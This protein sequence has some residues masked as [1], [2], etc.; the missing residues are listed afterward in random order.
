MS[1]VLQLWSISARFKYRNTCWHLADRPMIKMTFLDSTFYLKWQHKL[2]Q[3]LFLNWSK[4][5]IQ[6]AIVLLA[7]LFGYSSTVGPVIF[8]FLTLSCYNFRFSF[9]FV[10]YLLA[11]S[12]S[13]SAP[14]LVI[15]A[16]TV[17]VIW[18]K[19]MSTK[20]PCALIDWWKT[21]GSKEDNQK[22]KKFLTHRILFLYKY[23]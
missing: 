2:W 23:V 13:C 4:I 6:P 15:L 19:W 3:S 17:H 7:N 8:D 22:S 9:V 5:A 12:E 18:L 20:L 16:R 1:N 10:Y 14:Y 21:E 11:R